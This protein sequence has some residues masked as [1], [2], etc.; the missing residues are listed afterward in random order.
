MGRTVTAQ[1]MVIERVFDELPR[2]WLRRTQCNGGQPRGELSS[3][4]WINAGIFAG[5]IAAGAACGHC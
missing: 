2:P 4:R 1:P 5:M 3:P